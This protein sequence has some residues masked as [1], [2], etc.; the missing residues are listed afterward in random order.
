MS[1]AAE[2]MTREE[3]VMLFILGTM[4]GLIDKGLVKGG[5][6]RLSP[7]GMDE[8]RALAATGFSPTDAEIEGCMRVL[9]SDRDPLGDQ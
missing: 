3:Q 8:Y 2:P 4:Q 5:W 7:T 9:Q 1:S 6:V